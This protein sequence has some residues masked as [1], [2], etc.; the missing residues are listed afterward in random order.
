MEEEASC[1][2]MSITQQA[3]SVEAL[4][5]SSWSISIRNA[6][7]TTP[8]RGPESEVRVTEGGGGGSKAL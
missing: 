2:D 8:L 3:Q 7:T 4:G 6:P 1:E 5:T